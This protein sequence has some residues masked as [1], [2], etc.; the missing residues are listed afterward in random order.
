MNST[1]NYSDH[2]EVDLGVTYDKQGTQTGAQ[3][4]MNRQSN[5]TVVTE[6]LESQKN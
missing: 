2:F 1:G 6:F 4:R 5:G 3:A